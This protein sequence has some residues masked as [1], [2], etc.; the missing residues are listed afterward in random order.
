MNDLSYATSYNLRKR[1]ANNKTLIEKTVDL[2]DR[3]FVICNLYKHSYWLV[4]LSST[5]IVYLFSFF[6]VLLC[7]YFFIPHQFML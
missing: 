4:F 5:A 3:D 2:N 1:T 6:I 7:F